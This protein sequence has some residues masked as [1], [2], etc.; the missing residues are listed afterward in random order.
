MVAVA[1]LG[2]LGMGLGLTGQGPV[3]PSQSFTPSYVLPSTTIVEGAF[4]IRYSCGG[5]HSA[6][7]CAPELT[8]SSEVGRKPVEFAPSLLKSVGAIEKLSGKWLRA[9]IQGESETGLPLVVRISEVPSQFRPKAFVNLSDKKFQP[10]TNINLRTEAEIKPFVNIMVKFKGDTSEPA[11]ASY[12]DLL[13]GNTFP[14]LGLFF[15]RTSYGNMSTDGSRQFGWLTLPKTR[16]EYLAAGGGTQLDAGLIYDDACDLVDSQVDFR[17]YYGVNVMMNTGYEGGLWGLGGG[18]YMTRDGESRVWG[19]TCNGA[20]HDQFLLAHEVGHSIG[21]PHAS[22]QWGNEYGSNF[23]AMGYGNFAGGDPYRSVGVPYHQQYKDQLGWIASNRIYYGLPG[24]SQTIRLERRTLP[25]ASGYLMAKVFVGGYARKFITLESIKKIDYDGRALEGVCLADI[26]FSRSQRLRVLDANNNNTLADEGSLMRVGDTYSPGTGVTFEVVSADSTAYNVKITVTSSVPWPHQ[27]KST[28]DNGPQTLREAIEFGKVL[29]AYQ[30][31]FMLTTADPN[32]I[33]GYYKISLQSGL[34]TLNK[35]VTIDGTTQADTNPN[36]PEIMLDGTSAGDYTS[37]FNI[38]G[39]NVRIK[40][41]SIANFKASGLYIETA[42]AIGA[43]IE[44]N[45]I[46]LNPLGVAAKNAWDGITLRNGANSN[47][48]GGT[49]T[50]LGNVISGN[51]NR[52]IGLWD[53]TTTG[54][55]IQNNIIGANVS[56]TAA[57]ASPGGGAGI[58]IASGAS[59]NTITTNVISGNA[60]NGVELWNASSNN[61]VKGNKIG[62]NIAGTAAVAN[63][64]GVQIAQ[65]PTQNTIG[66][67]TAADRNIISGNRNEGITIW[68]PTTTGNLVQGN[69]IG[70][71]SDG[72]TVLPNNDVGI[73]IYNGS[74]QNTIG[75]PTT[76]HGNVIAG[77]GFTGIRSFADSSQARVENNLIGTNATGLL[78]RPNRYAIHLDNACKNWEIIGNVLSG[79]TSEAVI[80][81]DSGTEGHKLFGNFIGVARNGTTSLPN[82]GYGAIW[83]FGQAK[84]ITIGNISAGNGNTIANNTS[85]GIEVWGDSTGVTIRGNKIFNN[86]ALGINLDG[87]NGAGGVTQNDVNDVD[88]GANSLQ[89]FP[90]LSSAERVQSGIQVAGTLNSKPSKQYAIDFY[91]NDSADPTG[92]GE[93]THYLGSIVVTTNASGNVSF[94]SIIGSGQGTLVSATATEVATGDTSEFSALV[95]LPNALDSLTIDP[96]QVEGGS[97]ATGTVTLAAIASGP[98]V[99]DVSSSHPQVASSPF[100]VTIAAGTT[101][102]TFNI[103]T[104]VQVQ[105]VPVTFTAVSGSVSKTA[106]LLVKG[107]VALSNFTVN[108]TTV[109]AGNATTGT[110]RIASALGNDVTIALTDNSPYVNTPESVTIKAGATAGSVSITTLPRTT[111]TVTTITAIA[112]SST[113][114]ATLTSTPSPFLSSLGLSPKTV[115]GGWPVTG[116]INL[117]APAPVPVRIN[118]ADN[119]EAASTPSSVVIV[120]GAQSANFT[121]ATF[122]VTASTTVTVT[123]EYAGVVRTNTFAILPAPQLTRLTMTPASIKGGENSTGS[124][125]LS[126]KAPAGGITVNLSDNATYTTTPASVFVPENQLTATFI[127]TSVPVTVKRVIT[128]SATYKGV[129]KTATLTVNP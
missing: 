46:G 69:Y 1:I 109:V 67:Q 124:V 24:T 103:T 106:S 21:L 2:L 105:D 87:N 63:S 84:N 39:P 129:T 17:N 35:A 97:S 94:N 88:T 116:T 37:G 48:I 122:D 110:V 28:A 38:Q 64:V 8:I 81:R 80:I 45:F 111:T 93:G 119:S 83:V 99:V 53:S 19:F 127:V 120:K 57:L 54:N 27:I 59:S 118:T 98:I 12:Y 30:P 23:D 55:T 56:G 3:A 51:Q 71:G 82:G 121:I 58:T 79:N 104:N 14:G 89:N 62:V 74:Q 60:G 112:G 123:A 73:G 44:A 61:V 85:D 76:A 34:D 47:M 13:F 33:S 36:G 115:Y 32:Y 75:G 95:N 96:T 31:T 11:P 5:Q 113:R 126:R 4:A 7:E 108:P 70:L 66:G 15:S 52:N 29:P 9:E 72:S 90:V 41:L 86:G 128:I 43:R 92:Y 101:S 107:T 114:T 6:E 42:N 18:R 20:Y 16:A 49:S 50:A 26:D 78:A 25:T 117:A 125:L 65:G 68:D 100:S 10:T 40:G 77:H 102:K 91:G 22:D